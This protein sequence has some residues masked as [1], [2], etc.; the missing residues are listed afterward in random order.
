M[1][2][3]VVRVGLVVGGQN[4]VPD[5]DGVLVVHIVREVIESEEPDYEVTTRPQFTEGSQWV[6]CTS[7]L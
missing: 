3:G 4:L 6:A 7:Q 5:R 2:L 1:S